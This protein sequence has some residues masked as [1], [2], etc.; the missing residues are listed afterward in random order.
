MI[1]DARKTKAQLIEELNHLRETSGKD[2]ARHLLDRAPLP[3]LSV[4]GDA[5]ILTVNQAWLDMMGYRE[6][7]VIGRWTGDI[8]TPESQA[9]LKKVFPAY[10]KK[11][12]L[13]DVE[14]TY[15]KQDGTRILVSLDSRLEDTGD[16]L[17]FHTILHDITGK[18]RAEENLAASEQ[19]FRGLFESN[20]DGIIYLDIFGTILNVNPSFCSI[21]G[22]EADALLGKNIL[23][24]TAE[25]FSERENDFFGSQEFQSA[26]HCE[27]E[28]NMSTRT[29]IMCRLSS[30]FG[31]IGT[32]R[33]NPKA[34]GLL[35]GI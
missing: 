20:A 26:G 9:K 8:M 21:L 33:A 13:K 34:Y 35:S 29:G 4:D 30:E 17:R 31:S 27:Y 28:K 23:D 22:Y 25:P 11:G 15:I 14:Y 10:L 7:E 24:I 32:K 3:Y 6:E 1:S 18:R 2:S 19:R 16:G 12:E 5:R